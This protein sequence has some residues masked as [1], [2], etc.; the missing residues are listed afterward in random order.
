MFTLF[1]FA[2][3]SV[4]ICCDSQLNRCSSPT[5]CQNGGTCQQYEVSNNG[6]A[7]YACMCAPGYTGRLCSICMNNCASQ[8]VRASCLYRGSCVPKSCGYT[9]NCDK[10]YSGPFCLYSSQK[11]SSDQLT[12]CKVF[13]NATV[14]ASVSCYLQVNSYYYEY[15]P[16][17][18][19]ADGWS[20]RTCAYRAS[21]AIIG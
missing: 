13:M 6:S 18:A 17:C 15:L 19:C 7:L 3:A 4:I 1:F 20:G 5:D 9:C 10:A 16:I 8:S 11:C 2:F 14:T 21:D 12:Y